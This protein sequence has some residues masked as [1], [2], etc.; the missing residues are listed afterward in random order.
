MWFTLLTLL[1]GAER[2]AELVVAGR[3]RRWSLARGGVESGSR[4]YPV[5]VALQVGLL[6]GG[7][8]EVWLRRPPVLLPFALVMFILV[9]A[10]QALRWW[11]IGTLGRQWNTRIIVVP[12]LGLVRRGPY[13]W[14]RH[15]NYVAVVVEGIALPLTGAARITAIAFTLT[16]LGFLWV[17]IRAEQRA[18]AMAGTASAAR[19]D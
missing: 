14:L 2:I 5:V 9:L 7:P 17:R 18:L 15:P 16:N 10:A 1:I 8:V 13:R 11:C 12:G 19:S 4:H 6:V 3:N